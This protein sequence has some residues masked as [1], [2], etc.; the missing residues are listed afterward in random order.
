MDER[1]DPDHPS[2]VS[3]FCAETPSEL[4]EIGDF[5]RAMFAARSALALEAVESADDRAYVLGLRGP[6]GMLA[7]ARVLPLPDDEA[8]IRRFDHPAAQSHGM[9]TE[10][11]RLAT[12]AGGSPR[13]VLAILALGSYWMVKHTPHRSYVAYC[14]PR[15]ASLYESIGARDL[16]IETVRPGTDRR[17]RF[18]TGRFE[19][20]AE[21]LLT[22]LGFDS[23]PDLVRPAAAT[24]AA[25]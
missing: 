7:C 9:Q 10:V 5:R 19:H 20:T 11:G 15:L 13:L 4:A 24:V 17:Y 6:T 23:P 12:A 14:S 3:L 1:R 25:A 16:G 8:G 21:Q 22:H 2:A 18:V